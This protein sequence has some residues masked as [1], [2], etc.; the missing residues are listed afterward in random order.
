MWAPRKRMVRVQPPHLVQRSCVVNATIIVQKIRSTIF[1]GWS[2]NYLN[3]VLIGS[4][5]FW[6]KALRTIASKSTFWGTAPNSP[7]SQGCACIALHLALNSSLRFFLFPP[8]S[9]RALT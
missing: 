4:H 9:T 1:A 5:T 7:L 3:L 6:T 2:Y 8:N